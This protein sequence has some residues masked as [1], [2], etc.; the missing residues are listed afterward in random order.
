MAQMSKAYE[1]VLWDLGGVLT[2]SPFNNFSNYEKKN[3]LKLGTIIKINSR[4][5]LKNSWALVEKNKISKKEFY[6]LFKKEA[7]E[8]GIN[9]IDPKKVLE[10]LNVKINHDICNILDLIKKMYMCVCLTNNINKDYL[11]FKNNA[12]E[13]LKNN[14]SFVFESFKLGLR[15]PEKKIY[16][17][18]LKTI[19]IAP[20]K[21]LFLDDLGINLKP[22]KQL[23]INTYKVTDTKNT[24]N[25]LK[26][27]L[28]LL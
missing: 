23:G 22:A 24:I 2:H 20:E 5:H 10:C 13:S 21:I 15:K 12:L 7:S 17:V 26:K 8:I 19:N 6:T 3:G 18:V 11:P 25:F 1:A 9:N 16:E 14:F 27:E 28:R 4:N